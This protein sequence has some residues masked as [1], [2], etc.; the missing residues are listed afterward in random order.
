[1]YLSLIL[2]CIGG[3]HYTA[4]T[5][6]HHFFW[7]RRRIILTC[8]LHPHPP[9]NIG[10][11]AWFALVHEMCDMCHLHV[12]PTSRSCLRVQ[13]FF[14]HVVVLEATADMVVPWDWP[15]QQPNLVP[16]AEHLSTGLSR[17]KG[18]LAWPKNK[19]AFHQSSEILPFFITMA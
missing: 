8:A 13:A 4:N 7:P 9:W 5:P 15:S 6:K 16:C 14:P 17:P 18:D 3:G 11:N 19:H 10:I 1:M 2:L 12:E